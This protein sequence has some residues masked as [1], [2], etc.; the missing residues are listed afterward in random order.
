MLVKHLFAFTSHTVTVV[1]LIILGLGA[2]GCRDSA[3]ISEQT[4][5]VPLSG[6]TL[7]PLGTLQPD[8]SSNVT[9]YTATIPTAVDSV[10]VT[11]TPKNSTTTIIINGKTIPP[12]QGQAVAFEHP[13]LTK[14]VE[15]VASS[16]N[17]LE[18]TYRVTVTRLSNDNNI[19][20]LQVTAN[21]LVQPLS[22]TVKADTT[23]YTSNVPNTVGQVTVVATKS[24]QNATMLI[25]SGTTSVSIGPGVN[26]GQLVV[27]LG[28]PGTSSPVS[29][30]V[31][32]PNSSKKIYQVTVNRLSGNNTLREL[33]V[34]P[35]TFDRPF[36]PVFTTYIVTAPFT[37]GE[38]TITATKS[39]RLA[40][41]TGSL[42]AGAGIESGTGKFSLGGPGSELPFSLIVAAPDPTVPLNEYRITVK[43]AFPSS[44]ADLSALTT[45]PGSL[46]P[47]TFSPNIKDY[48]VKVGLLIDSVTLTMTKADS[49]A[50]LS[51]S[52]SIL[53]GVG[54]TTGT[55]PVFPGLGANPPIEILVT[56]E[57]QATTTTYRVTV[58]RGLF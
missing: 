9:S 4:T 38:V 10:M 39:D 21:N 7:T 36:D 43:K 52:N 28:E 42:T 34:I 5:A 55:V 44:N 6:L 23:A 40:A 11:A 31:T 47:S 45:S 48:T 16:Q 57:D 46:E 58:E 26:P 54:V 27:P 41:M 19:S 18:S 15:V 8:F 32:A 12:G 20:A 33:F 53:A 56:A 49:N 17:G 51:I 30:E 22:P 3:S 13:G 2:S 1:L 25:R 29:I 14:T 24:D 35:G 37:A 50:V